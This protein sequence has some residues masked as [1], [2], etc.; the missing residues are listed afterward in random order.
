MNNFFLFIGFLLILI[1]FLKYFNFNNIIKKILLFFT[2]KEEFLNKFIPNKIFKYNDKIYILDTKH[3]LEKNINPLIFNSFK[4]YQEFIENIKNTIDID[5]DYIK[6]I[7][8]IDT[9]NLKII[10]KDNTDYYV[11]NKDMKCNRYATECALKYNTELSNKQINNK[12]NNN[13]NIDSPFINKIYNEEELNKLNKKCNPSI[14]KE[15]CSHLEKLY[16]NEKKYNELCK[17]DPGNKICKDIDLIKYNTKNIEEI[18][19][20][21]K[22]DYDGYKK[23]CLL[24]DFF[25]EN[26]LLYN[27]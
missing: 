26:M 3:I 9:L 6:T 24:E 4:E 10:N 12:F 27:F 5:F 14:N 2:T 21:K 17:K 7:K 19:V 15:R 22:R 1:Y 18:C 11:G 20:N 23:L 8:E 16:N 13:M 25:K